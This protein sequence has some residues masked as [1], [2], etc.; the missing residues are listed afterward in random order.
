MGPLDC[1]HGNHACA[2]YAD[3]AAAIKGLTPITIGA[4]LYETI[5]FIGAL[6]SEFMRIFKTIAARIA[7]TASFLFLLACCAC[8]RTTPP[9][10]GEE[11]TGLKAGQVEPK[12]VEGGTYPAVKP[13]LTRPLNVEEKPLAVR[14]GPKRGNMDPG[15]EENKI[16][17]KAV[18]GSGQLE[19][20]RVEGGKY[21]AVKPNL[22]QPLNVEEAPYIVPKG[23]VREKTQ[24]QNKE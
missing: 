14:N 10:L 8:N 17:K 15:N 24:P 9:Q 2:A 19:P 1:R 23:P 12:A 4:T 16:E 11:K 22:T 13:D 6:I 3:L 20:N 7:N 5:S 18:S 21:P